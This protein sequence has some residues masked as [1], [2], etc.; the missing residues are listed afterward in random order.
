M[1]EQVGAP[2]ADGMGERVSLVD[3][4]K[5]PGRRYEPGV[6]DSHSSAPG[7]GGEDLACVKRSPDVREG[8]TSVHGES[9]AS[10]PLALREGK[11]LAV[12][13]LDPGR[14]RRKEEEVAFDDGCGDVAEF[15][16]VVLG[17]VAQH[18]E[19]VVGVGGVAGHEDAFGLFDDGAPAE[20]ADRKSV[21]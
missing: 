9:L 21:V 16:A 3:C 7:T 15:A 13:D 10:L 2:V 20:C 1:A 14:C 6:V 12:G 11:T 8:V 17:V 19:G 5:S 4:G 18:L